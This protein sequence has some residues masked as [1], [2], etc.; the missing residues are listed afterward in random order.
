[1]T[2]TVKLNDGH[3]MPLLGLGVMQIADDDTPR[4]MRQAADLG[5]RLFD[6]APVYGNEAGTGRGVRECGLPREDV[7]V[8]TK[9][10]NT[11]Q[12]Y[13][14]ALRA[15]DESQAALGLDYV[16]LYLIHW[17]VPH[18]NL[19]LDSWKALIRLRDE[20]RV[21]SIGVSNFMVEHLDHIVAET[22]VAPAVNQIEYH[23]AWQQREAAERGRAH[24]TVTQ[25]WS[26]LGRGPILSDS[27]VV[28]AAARIG[29]T[30]AQ[31]VL[32]WLTQSD[33]AAIPKAS[34]EAHMREN[35]ESLKL[36]LDASAIALLDGMHDV[37][38][39]IGPDPHVFEN[40]VR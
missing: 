22:G 13:D 12:G 1:M 24:A 7:F 37:A 30:P 2:M 40:L 36:E 35:L 19:Y 15:F 18:R 38:G 17:P 8:T 16:D 20:G 3:V 31:L 25:A 32:R 10:W 34:G 4:A 11:R 39:R 27:R 33:I 26:P 29:C 23:P 5:Y 9:L 6:T 21:R 14:E 28:E